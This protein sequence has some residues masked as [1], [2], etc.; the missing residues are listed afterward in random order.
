MINSKKIK[1]VLVFASSKHMGDLI[2]ALP[3]I[4]ALKKSFK[5]KKFYLVADSAY[6]DIVETIEGLGNV[7]PYPRNLLKASPGIKRSSIMF[8]FLR[9]LR[10][11]SPDIAIDL[12]GTVASST[13]TFLSGARLRVGRSTAKR[14]YLYNHKVNISGGMHKSYSYTEIA[15]AAGVKSKIEPPKTRASESSMAALKSILHKAGIIEKKPVVCVHPGAG[16]I[17]KEWTR[18]G[19]ADVSDWLTSRGFQVVFIGGSK[20]LEGINKITSLTQRPSFNLGGGL[21]IG[22]LIALLEASALYIGNDSGPMHLA[23]AVGAPV[24]AM[25]GPGCENM[26]RPLTE[27]AVILRGDERCAKCTGKHCQ[28]DFKCIKRISSDDVKAAVRR[29]ITEP[30]KV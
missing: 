22:E 13:M 18:E 9:Q 10:N 1:N 24:I 5:E 3:A 2:L 29:L 28:Y 7:I 15:S 21:S 19:F 14:A 12:Q 23:G 17:Y 26:W 30:D 27:R 16:V 25:F 6:K 20:D 4:D 11:S 8:N